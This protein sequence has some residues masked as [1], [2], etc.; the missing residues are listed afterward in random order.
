MSQQPQRNGPARS[1]A[2]EEYSSTPA[3]PQQQILNCRYLGLG[4][5]KLRQRQR[6][7]QRAGQ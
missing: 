2:P 3:D 6:N 7:L 5:R 1:S 4:L